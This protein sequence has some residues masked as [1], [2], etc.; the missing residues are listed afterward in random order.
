[1]EKVLVAIGVVAVGV[2]AFFVAFLLGMRA[3]SPRVLNTVRRVNRAFFNKMQMRSAGT[4]EAYAAV[5]HHRGRGSGTP[6]ETPVGAEP[7][8]DGFVIAMVY[9]TNSDWLKNVLAAGEAEITSEG[10]TVAVDRPEV[11]PVDHVIDYFP[12][13]TRRSLHR[14]GVTDAV[15]VRRAVAQELPPDVRHERDEHRDVVR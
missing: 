14:F 9:G 4:P 6:Y 10:E 1:M 5:V 12:A 13:K 15:R 7:T 11:V 2:A 8:E 3:R